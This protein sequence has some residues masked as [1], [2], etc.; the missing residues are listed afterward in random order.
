MTP[1]TFLRNAPAHSLCLGTFPSLS[2]LVPMSR[3]Q[4]GFFADSLGSWPCLRFS[5]I[6]QLWSPLSYPLISSFSGISVCAYTYP[7]VRWPRS[8]FRS[9]QWARTYEN[10]RVDPFNAEFRVIGLVFKI[11]SREPSSP[12]SSSRL[13]QSL[14]I[15]VLTHGLGRGV[16]PVWS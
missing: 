12:A 10:F 8:A 4:A 14:V 13:P 16:Y 1:P 6:S 2:R 9:L 11:L 3:S 7:W 15:S 5:F